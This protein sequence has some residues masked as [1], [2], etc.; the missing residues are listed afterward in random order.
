MLTQDRSATNWLGDHGGGLLVADLR[1]SGQPSDSARNR[2]LGRAGANHRRDGAG[3]GCVGSRWREPSRTAS[4]RLRSSSS[5]SFWPS[6]VSQSTPWFSLQRS[7]ARSACRGAWNWVGC[8]SSR[9]IKLGRFAL[10]QLRPTGRDRLGT[11]IRS[12]GGT[13]WPRGISPTGFSDTAKKTP[14][15]RSGFKVSR[16]WPS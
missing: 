12:S 16:G 14:G 6:G 5:H 4:S 9:K 1:L 2:P 13:K 10:L 3:L 7:L 11:P 15:L 8:R